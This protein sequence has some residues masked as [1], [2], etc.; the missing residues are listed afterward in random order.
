MV[1]NRWDMLEGV[2]VI[3][4]PSRVL[5][6]GPALMLSSVGNRMKGA[7]SVLQVGGE[8]R[9]IFGN[10]G[11]CHGERLTAVGSGALLLHSQ[12]F[13]WLR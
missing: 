8:I 11:Q 9:L 12:S 2:L 10:H 13:G 7:Y 1:T 3:V 4:Q 6:L 5:A